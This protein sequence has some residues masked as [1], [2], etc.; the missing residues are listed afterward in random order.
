VFWY[1]GNSLMWLFFGKDVLEIEYPLNRD[2]SGKKVKEIGENS[3]FSVKLN[4][5]PSKRPK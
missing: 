4:E 2:A 1:E 5:E 3:N